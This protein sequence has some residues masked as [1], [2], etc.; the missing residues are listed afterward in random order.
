[1]FCLSK[2]LGAPIGSMLT[3]TRAFIAAARHVRKA[4]GGG[5]RQVGVI[6]AA[7]LVALEETPPLLA[8]DHANAQR[9]A[10][11]MAEIP[12]AVIDPAAFPTNI[13]FLRTKAG[14]PSYPKI[15]AALEA[16]SV[17]AFAID[18]LGVRFVT[19][20]DLADEDIARA[21]DV[22]RRVVPEVGR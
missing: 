15:Q 4:L 18:D 5:M 6:A 11:G 20:R 19:H 7:G 21:L 12:G 3:G 16:A 1:M 22:L 2:G 9:L 10:R 8:R 13:V 14:P 17:L